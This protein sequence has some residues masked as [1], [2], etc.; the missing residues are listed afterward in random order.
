MKKVNFP[1]P[2]TTVILFFS[3]IFPLNGQ[4]QVINVFKKSYEYENNGNYKAAIEQLNSVYETESYEINLRLGWLYYQN[5][6]FKESIDYYQKAINLKP[7][8]IEPKLGVVLP[9]S[10]MGKWEAV[11]EIY[12]KILDIDPNNS[13]V[14]YRVGL[15]YYN[16]GNF[17]QAERYI[18]KVVNLY[19]FDYDSLLLLGWIKLKL[20]KNREAK[21]LFQKALMNRPGDES[22]L[23]GLKYIK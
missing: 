3:I 7:Y 23:E 14:N 21:V 2:F 6:N 10:S 15:L 13:L 5:G 11:L 1:L 8:A 12:Q 17:N 4:D 22:A 19:P 16:K 18:E 9:Y 20:Q